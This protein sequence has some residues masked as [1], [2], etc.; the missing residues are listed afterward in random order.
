MLSCLASSRMIL[1]LKDYDKPWSTTQDVSV[2]PGVL[3]TIHFGT[4]DVHESENEI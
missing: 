2:R 4:W 1:L 3:S